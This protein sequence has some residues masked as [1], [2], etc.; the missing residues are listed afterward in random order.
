MF[1]SVTTLLKRIFTK[2]GGFYSYSMLIYNFYFLKC[3]VRFTNP[4]EFDQI[5]ELTMNES[6][7]IPIQNPSSLNQIAVCCPFLYL[8]Y[9]NQLVCL[10]YVTGLLEEVPSSNLHNF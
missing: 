9:A 2:K 3:L 8:G 5:Q 7:K 1:L 10:C 4:V 6:F